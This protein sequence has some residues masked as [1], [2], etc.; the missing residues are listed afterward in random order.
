MY[1][2]RYYLRTICSCDFKYVNNLLFKIVNSFDKEFIKIE[3]L[4]SLNIANRLYKL[5]K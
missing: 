3:I 4:T 5:Y 1:F 2:V